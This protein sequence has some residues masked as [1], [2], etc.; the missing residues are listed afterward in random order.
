MNKVKKKY[1]EVKCSTTTK[2]NNLICDITSKEIAFITGKLKGINKE[3]AFIYY[4]YNIN[5]KNKTAKIEIIDYDRFQ[6]L[7]LTPTNYK[8]SGILLPEVI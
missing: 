8:V 5:E 2:K 7:I 6:Q 3:H 4:V 1:I